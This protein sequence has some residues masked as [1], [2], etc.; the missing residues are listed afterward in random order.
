MKVR[1]IGDVPIEKRHG[2]TVGRI[3]EVSRK[4]ER[5]LDD[6]GLYLRTPAG[7]PLVYFLGDAD[8]EVG[9]LRGEF[10]EVDS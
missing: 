6:D 5:V 8:E 2:A 10:E 1:I 4:Y 9:L 3:V 7:Q